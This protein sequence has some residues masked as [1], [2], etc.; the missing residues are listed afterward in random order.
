MEHL[1][2]IKLEAKCFICTITTELRNKYSQPSSTDE[3]SEAL[4]N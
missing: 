3:V 4:C 1:L 2:C